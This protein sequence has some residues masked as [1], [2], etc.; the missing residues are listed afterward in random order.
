MSI[1]NKYIW[2]VDTL[3][4]AGERGISLKE[5]NEKWIQNE[6]LSYGEPIPRQTFD[7]WKGNILDMLGVIIECHTKGGYRYYIENPEILSN[8]RLSRWLLD[9]YTTANNLS[10]HASLHNRIL[11]EEIPSNRDFLAFIINAMKDNT[12][13]V[14]TY[15]NFI[16][17]KENSFPICPYC[18]KM[19]QKRWYTLALSVHENKLRI[20]ALDRIVNAQLTEQHFILPKDFDAKEYFASYFG[21]VLDETVKEQRIILRAYKPHQNYLRTLPLHPSQKEIYTCDAYAD[22]ELSL[23]PTYDFAMELLHAGALVEVLEPESLRK[24]MYSWVKDLWNMYK[25]K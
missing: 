11:V 13:V 20:Y 4:Q 15:K 16:T 18:L 8:D 7:R 17:E 5:L 6:S 2:I 1:L 3:Y 22:F 14:L 24:Q 19:F 21:M 9:T 10:K 25:N 23:R 12:V